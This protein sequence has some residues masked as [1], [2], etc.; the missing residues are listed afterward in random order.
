MVIKVSKKQN[1]NVL[2]EVNKGTS[3][4]M[5]AINDVMPKVEDEDFKKVLQGEY[6]KY[7][8]IHK[9]I[10]KIYNEFESNEEPTETSIMNKMMTSFMVDMKTIT[11]TSNSKIAELLLQGTNMGIIEGKKLLNHKSD[12]D[13]RVEI[14]LKD[15]VAMQED[16]VETLKKYL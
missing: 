7:N 1:K 16:S 12:L 13:E 9:R 6:D 2:D 5:D 14:I 4:G 8:K 10:E 3:M 15:F 11:D